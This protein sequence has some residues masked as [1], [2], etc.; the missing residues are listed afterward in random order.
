MADTI[1]LRRMPSAGSIGTRLRVSKRGGLP[2]RRAAR[3]KLIAAIEEG[4]RVRR[5]SQVQAAKV[6]G[7]DQPTLSKVLRGRTESVTLDKLM[8]WLL[9]LGRSVELRIGRTNL[10]DGALTAVIEGQHARD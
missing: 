3:A 7:T 6:C 1:P 8:A 9:A 10:E 5:L 2:G 4:I